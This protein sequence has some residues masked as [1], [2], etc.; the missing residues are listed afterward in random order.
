MPGV[1]Y[2]IIAKEGA[3]VNAGDPVVILEAMKMENAVGSPIDGTIAEIKVNE[4]DQ[5]SGGDVL[6]V[7]E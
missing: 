6:A 4:G 3:K 5:V 2:K 7:I 1:V